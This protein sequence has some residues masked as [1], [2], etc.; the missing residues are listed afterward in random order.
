MNDDVVPETLITA[1]NF[2]DEVSVFIFGTADEKASPVE[3]LNLG[4][5]NGA[6]L[7]H[8]LQFDISSAPADAVGRNF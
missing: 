1:G 4:L 2:E 8:H 5:E 3:E 7:F 6:F